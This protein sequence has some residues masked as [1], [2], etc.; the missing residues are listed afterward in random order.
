VKR[1]TNPRE[2]LT[3]AESDRVNA[4][5]KNAERDTSAEIK[6]VVARHCWSDIKNKASGIFKKLGLDKTK[7]HNG[8]L[9]LFIV[10]NREFLVYGDQGIH[11]KVGQDFWND[12]R[13][14]MSADFHEGRFADGICDG[15]ELIGKKLAEYFP[16]KR[17]DINEI[18]DEIV[19]ER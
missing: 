7:E 6:L 5:I 9:I 13:D 14:R 15:I 19:Y 2:F 8:V 16:H 1:P 18:A 12:I 3:P 17:G 10:T 4:A 11:E